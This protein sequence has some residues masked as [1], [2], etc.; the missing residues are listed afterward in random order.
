MKCCIFLVFLIS[1][2]AESLRYSINW[3]SGLSLGE[4][5]LSSQRGPAPEEGPEK[6]PGK[7]LGPWQFTLEIDASVPGFAIRDHDNSAATP[8]L[9]GVNLDKS[10]QHGKRSSEE[11]LSFDQHN[12]TVSRETS[13]GGKSDIPVSSC[14]R[15]AL[16]FIQ[17]V[18][19][20]LAQGRV[21]PPQQVVFGSLY[22]VTVQYMGTQTIRLGE[23]KV[24]A[25][26][27]VAS[28]KGA[29]SDLT[30]EIFFARDAAR[31]PLMAK[32]PLALGTFTVELEP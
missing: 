10:A 2:Q 24:D 8:D 28:I 20:E 1:A 23:K 18:R 29:S 9:C 4:A 7:A 16:S 6:G 27:T 21:A 31:T 11:K 12:N 30:V 13:G 15:D 14:A 26:R 19:S 5:T 32:V 3:P 22:Q 17:F 25:D